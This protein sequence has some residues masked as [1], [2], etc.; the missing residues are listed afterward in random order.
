MA[1]QVCFR[2]T[3]VCPQLNYIWIP[4]NQAFCKEDALKTSKTASLLGMDGKLS[5]QHKPYEKRCR[6]EGWNP[7]E[8]T[9]GVGAETQRGK[10]A[11]EDK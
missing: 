10:A 11:E 9:I 7:W 6:R 2:R 1:T 5:G 4:Q 8:V 3:V